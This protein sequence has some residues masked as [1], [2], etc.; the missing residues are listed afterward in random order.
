MSAVSE[1]AVDV[2]TNAACQA[3]RLPRASYYWHRRKASAPAEASSPRPA[4]IPSW[5]SSA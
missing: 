3:L 4:A 2:G 5:S 1:L